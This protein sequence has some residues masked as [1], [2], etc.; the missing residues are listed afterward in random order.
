M[1]ENADS[2]QALKVVGPQVL[3]GSTYTTA[4]LSHREHMDLL[5]MMLGD[6]F[7]LWNIIYDSQFGLIIFNFHGWSLS[8]LGF[9]LYW[10]GPR[11]V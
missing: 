1:K 6:T 8:K 11:L 4:S 10:A 5:Y 3:K 9:L 2:G 7:L